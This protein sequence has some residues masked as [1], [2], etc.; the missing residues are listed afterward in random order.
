MIVLKK[1]YCPP[2]CQARFKLK[3]ANTFYYY[4]DFLVGGF[5]QIYSINSDA[6]IGETAHF[7]FNF[8]RQQ[9]LQNVKLEIALC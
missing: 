8:D 4:Y 7:K 5:C 1:L 3:F 6:I 2:F 9:F